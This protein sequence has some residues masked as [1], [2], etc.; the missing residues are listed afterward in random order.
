MASASVGIAV[1]NSVASAP[2]NAKAWNTIYHDVVDFLDSVKWARKHLKSYTAK[3]VA[4]KKIWMYNSAEWNLHASLFLRSSG[5]GA[6]AHN[7]AFMQELANIS[8]GNASGADTNDDSLY[9]SLWGDEYDHIQDSVHEVMRRIRGINE[10]I[11][12]I[13]NEK[14][15]SP[16]WKKYLDVPRIRYIRNITYALFSHSSLQDE[17]AK[18]EVDIDDLTK[19]SERRLETMQRNTANLKLTG[20]EAF[21]LANLEY[22]GRKILKQLPAALPTASA[23]SLELCHPG[24]S[25]SV[26]DWQRLDLVKLRLSYTIPGVGQDDVVIQARKRITLDYFLG[27]DPDPPQWAS[28]LPGAFPGANPAANPPQDLVHNPILI[29]NYHVTDRLT[30][31][32]S[33]LFRIWNGDE[34]FRAELWAWDQAYLVLSL[35]NW[36]LLLWTSD[37]TATW[38]SSGLH[39][40]RVAADVGMVGRDD[41]FFPSFSKCALEEPGTAV[42]QGQHQHRDCFHSPLKLCNLGLVLAEAICM[43]PLRVSTT[44]QDQYEKY[45]REEWRPVSEAALLDLV[46]EQTARSKSVRDAV[47]RCLRSTATFQSTKDELAYFFAKYVKEVFDP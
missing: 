36:S 27:K 17:I 12:R 46:D 6:T 3:F 26:T 28:S 5:D 9:K 39:F 8:A 21:R 44:N 31:P 4:W 42:D 19:A 20:Q 13:V 47:Q 2:N 7:Q 25:G 14:N 43:I 37:W 32:F 24:T 22:F 18:L 33:H 16:E 40:V 23:W 29:Q 1:A 35:A 34:A 15:N 10:H 45:I 30:V 38:C 41:F 11:D